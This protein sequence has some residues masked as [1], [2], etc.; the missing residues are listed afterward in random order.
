MSVMKDP[1]ESKFVYVI[2]SAR[3][4][5]QLQSGARPLM[6]LPRARK[7]TRIAMEELSLGLLEYDMPET[8]GEEDKEGKRR[9]V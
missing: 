2:I 1:P 3:R 8:P 6:D 4:A 9:K 5:R 7:P